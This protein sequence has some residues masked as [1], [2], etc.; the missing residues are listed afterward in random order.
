MTTAVPG[1]RPYRLIDADTHVNEPP[2]LWTERVPAKYRDRVPHMERF[3]EGDAWVGE[4][5]SDPINFGFNASATLARAD[6]T[7]WVRF[8]DIPAGGYDPAARLREL[9][10]DLIDAA[11]FYPT[12]RLSHIV[13][14]NPDPDLHL[15]MVRAYND[16]LIDYCAHDPSRLGAMILLPN[17]G[18]DQAA[19]EIERVGQS[20][21]VTG[22]L[23]G[24]Y[25]H[26]D[27]DLVEEDDYVF[28]ALAEAGLPLHIHVGLVDQYPADVY[29]PGRITA[30]RAAGDLRFMQAVPV[31]VQLLNS[32][33]LDRV[34]DLPI[35]FV[36]VDAGWVPYIKEQMDN[37]WRRRA[38]GPTARLATLPSQYI[39]ER[40]SFTCITDQYAIAN[41][42]RIGTDRLLWSS[43][44]PHSGSDW[45]NSWRS[46]DATFADVPRHERDAILAGNAQRLYGFGS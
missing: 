39:E 28:R 22:A 13:I 17:R 23:M 30:G 9:D 31:L 37:R 25:P 5:V 36:E 40:F 7:P 12:P 8:E 3:E 45:P 20:T 21:A 32:G 14:A 24:C 44:F 16:W 42:H 6:R 15:A 29:A 26:G 11:V 46:I 18:I 2:D 33:V 1:P 41:R 27:T 10:E 38:S 35:V 43:D 34:P 19:S 4:G